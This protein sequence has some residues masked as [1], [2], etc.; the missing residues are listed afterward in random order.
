MT[1]GS[2]VVRQTAW[3][4]KKYSTFSD[5]VALVRKEL[6]T[7]EE[8]FCGSAQETDTVKVPGNSWKG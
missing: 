7:Q 6:W 4:R 8:A 2:G 5:A 3:Y 1:Q